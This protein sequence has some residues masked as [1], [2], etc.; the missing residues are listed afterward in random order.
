MAVSVE[1]TPEVLTPG[2]VVHGVMPAAPVDVVQ[3]KWH[4]SAAVTL[5]YSVA[6]GRAELAAPSEIR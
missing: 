1:C 4:G 6:S 2:A 3:A 5:T